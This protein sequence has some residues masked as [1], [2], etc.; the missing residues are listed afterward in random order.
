MD[1]ENGIHRHV[2]EYHAA[3][4]NYRTLSFVP[5]WKSLE[6]IMLHKISQAQKDKCHIF[7]THMWKLNS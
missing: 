1:R 4:K 6:V 5:T 3:M 7:L 2:H